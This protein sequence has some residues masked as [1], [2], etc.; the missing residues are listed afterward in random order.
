LEVDTC[1]KKTRGNVINLI[2]EVVTRFKRKEQ[3][4]VH[5]HQMSEEARGREA[6][7]DDVMVAEEEKEEVVEVAVVGVIRNS[8]L[9][10]KSRMGLFV[11]PCG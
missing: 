10:K 9:C 11:V 7:L 1:N 2:V 5:P 6:A 8:R 3:A 4:I